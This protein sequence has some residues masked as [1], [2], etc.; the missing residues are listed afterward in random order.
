MSVSTNLFVRQTRYNN[1]GWYGVKEGEDAD[2]QHK[3]FEFVRFGA[4]TFHQ[5]PYLQ[6]ILTIIVILNR[7]RE[8]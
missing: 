1:N 2:S 4:S 6:R 7:S 5:R 3:L 8:T